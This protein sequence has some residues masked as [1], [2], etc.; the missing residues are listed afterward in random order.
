MNPT[1]QILGVLLNLGGV[2]LCLRMARKAVVARNRTLEAA[3]QITAT[4]QLIQ[5]EADRAEKANQAAQEAYQASVRI[6]REG[7]MWRKEP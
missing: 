6:V 4:L 3:R 1:F 7:N 5:D 2:L